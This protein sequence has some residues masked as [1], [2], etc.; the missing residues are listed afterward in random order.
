MEPEGS[1]PCSQEPATGLCPEP[2]QSSP[3]HP[4]LPLSTN[5]GTQQDQ[6]EIEDI[7]RNE[8]GKW[9]RKELNN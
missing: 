3:Y 7:E 8:H 6:I 1:V 5:K 2:D 4:V 9:D